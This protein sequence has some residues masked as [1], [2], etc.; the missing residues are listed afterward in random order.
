MIVC[1]TLCTYSIAILF[2]SAVMM[3]DMRTNVQW[4][5]GNEPKSSVA[6]KQQQHTNNMHAT[7]AL[8]VGEASKRGL[9]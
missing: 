7:Y 1:C 9:V 8:H 4:S 2:V 6:K 3:I 5:G